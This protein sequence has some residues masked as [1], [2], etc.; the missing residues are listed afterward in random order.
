MTKGIVRVTGLVI[1]VF[2]TE[3]E[4]AKVIEEYSR[5]HP[6]KRF[7]DIVSENG[8]VKTE[9]WTYKEASMNAYSTMMADIDKMPCSLIKKTEKETL[10][11]RIRQ[12]YRN[13]WTRHNYPENISSMLNEIL[14]EKQEELRMEGK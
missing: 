1:G 3:L 11:L 2:T 12:K 4:K 14:S 5:F 13:E 6:G 8:S 10:V 7:Y 9:V